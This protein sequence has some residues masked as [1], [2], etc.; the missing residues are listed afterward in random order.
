MTDQDELS[1]FGA[2]L[3]EFRTRR[4]LTQQ[5]L[6]TAV[7]VHRNAVSR[8]E[9]GVFL[10][11]QKS[12]VLE[13]A[14]RLHL[15]DQETRHLLEASLTTLSPFFLVPLPR[16]PFFT[17]REEI[18]EMLHEQLDVEQSTVLARS[19]ALCGLGGVG[20]TQIALE[21]AYR[22]TLHY[23]AV[24]WIGAE[25]E[26]QIV[27]G[28]LSIAEVLQLPGHENQ[29]QQ[30]RVAAV[31]R[32][33][34]SHDQ[35]LLILDN[36]EELSLL[37][38]FLPPVRS[39]A[40]LLTTRCQTMG[41]WAHSLELFPLKQEE[42]LLLLL[43]RAKILAPEALG[44]Q[45]HQWVSL[46]PASSLAATALVETLGGLPLA[47]DQAGAY[48]EATHCGV[49]QYLELFQQ[50]Q[51]PLLA[52]R[53]EGTR[54]EE[55]PESVSTTF[56]LAITKAT[57]RHPALGDLLRVCTFL[58]ADAI[59]EDLFRQGGEY[60]GAELSA[61]TGSDLAW[62]QLMASACGY[63]LLSR[64]PETGTLS[65]HRLVQMVLHASF[66]E[67]EQAVWR[68]RILEA[69]NT[70]F[71][72]LTFASTAEVRKQH[73]RF[74][75]HVLAVL[76]SLPDQEGSQVLLE[77][78][79]KA[80]DYLSDGSPKDE[81]AE[82]LYQ[83]ALH[84]GERTLGPWHGEVAAVLQGLAGLYRSQ[85]R[86]E[87]AEASFQRA[88]RI[89][90]QTLGPEHPLT[91]DLLHH[92]AKLYWVQGKYESVEPLYQ[93][94]LRIR[95][96][97]LGPEHPE[98]ADS[99]T[100]LASLYG[101]QGKYEQAEF[102]FQRAHAILKGAFGSEHP[103]VA[104]ACH[105]L[106]ELNLLQGKYEQAEAF[107]QQALSIWERDLGPEH[108]DVSYP[109]ISLADLYTKWRRG[110]Q[111]EPLYQRA[112]QIT[113]HA[114]GPEHPLVALA[115]NGLANLYAQQGKQKQA[116]LLYERALRIQEQHLGQSHPETAQTLS[117]LA[118]LRQQQGRLSE[119]LT[120][121]ERTLQIRS[122]SL[123]DA[124]PQTVASRT[125]YAQLGEARG[126]IQERGP[127]PSS[128]E[129][130]PNQ[131]RKGCT[132]EEAFISPQKAI[133]G[134]PS[135]DDPLQEFLDACCELHPRAWCLSADL[136]QAYRDWV[137][138]RHEL[139][140]LSRRAL[141]TQ[142]KERGCHADRT[143]TA[144]IWRGIALVKNES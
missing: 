55:H 96:Q 54:A 6:A 41:T 28:L 111:A 23:R 88:L 31:H 50:E 99:F 24:L 22:H 46:Y 105:N 60:L 124:H 125:L 30:R 3:K 100:G 29:D 47:L 14:K 65:L 137:K 49:A 118:L 16:N 109:L 7:G 32:W 141:I 52:Y 25:T 70:V 61:V 26:E 36:V 8:W 13:L 9:Q 4:H 63:S 5:Q 135:E 62:N 45:M 1:A 37:D 139:Y 67:Q 21:Y 134:P 110:K 11:K 126:D 123:G 103:Y 120:L 53:G 83:R 127:V 82:V 51:A 64:H 133:D 38:R 129:E 143:M 93:R 106:A 72:E 80:A 84:V 115:L 121:A 71:P 92:L 2:L 43:R 87:Q 77:L 12:I 40:I 136:W 95:E 66:N 130:L 112:L 39:G 144:R 44:Q 27:S 58:Q 116:E 132:G 107:F 17:G 91:A 94:A 48:L 33:L 138:E 78:L 76:R 108:P 20:K 101:V 89:R 114:W 57:H 98:V 113:E 34:T 59:P 74:F 73:R 104:M 10:P 131:G 90:E 85:G 79:R 56:Q 75:P 42:G 119:A 35:W 117:D 18:L 128:A 142:L 140:P 86:Y 68:R 122:Q 69:L 102:L 97:T 19:S 15:A 81:Q